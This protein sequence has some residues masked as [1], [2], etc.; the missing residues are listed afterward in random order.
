MKYMFVRQDLP[1]SLDALA[2]YISQQT[3]DFHYNKH[4]KA[5]VDKLNTL[6][7]GTN[8]ERDTL[9]SII[10]KSYG[11]ESRTAIFNNASQAYNHD[12]F[13]KC[14]TPAV[15]K[16]MVPVELEQAVIRSFGS[17]EAM[18]KEFKDAALSLFGSGWVWLAKE[19]SRL[20]IIKS[21]NGENPIINGSRPLL[22]L[23]VWEHSY[24]LDYQN[25]RAEFIDAVVDNLIDWDFVLDNLR[26]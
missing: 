11:N 7:A 10:L 26:Q 9:E 17:F 13:W 23:D 6:V 22:G 20:V 24:Y 2:P 1:Y 4:H 25:R 18:I 3:M 15:N 21:P 16:K 19:D 8:L 14:L 12:F 5:Y